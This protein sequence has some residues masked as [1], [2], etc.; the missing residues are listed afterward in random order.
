MHSELV[1]TMH[2]LR[3]CLI[4]ELEIEHNKP[5]DKPVDANFYDSDSTANSQT[6]RQKMINLLT[7]MIMDFVLDS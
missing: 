5:T 2:T 6:K 7:H 1:E 3:M 4:L